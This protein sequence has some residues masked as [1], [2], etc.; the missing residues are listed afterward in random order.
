[1]KIIT[2]RANELEIENKAL[3]KQLKEKKINEWSCEIK[4][5]RIRNV[6]E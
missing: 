1:M 5:W 2:R 3:K 6:A 4:S